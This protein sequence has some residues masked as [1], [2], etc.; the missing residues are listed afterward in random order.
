[1]TTIDIHAHF[2]DRH[3][4]DGLKRVM[5]LDCATSNS[6]TTRDGTVVT[7]VT[8]LYLHGFRVTNISRRW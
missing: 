3:Y 1:M 6:N 7:L 8:P 2:V 4:L 5:R